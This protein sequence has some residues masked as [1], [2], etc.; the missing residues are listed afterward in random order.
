MGLSGCSPPY[1]EARVRALACPRCKATSGNRCR[2]N[3]DKIMPHGYHMLR[4]A[5]AYPRFGKKR[6]GMVQATEPTEQVR[7]SR[8]LET[9]KT[10][11]HRGPF[12][13]DIDPP[14]CA[15]CIAE[16]WGAAARASPPDSGVPLPGLTLV[17][18]G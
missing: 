5:E 14:G 3:K 17:A 7:C 8:C 2:T 11:P 9:G 15:V 10:A 16:V 12:R 1:D 6:R 18:P 13:A 4:K